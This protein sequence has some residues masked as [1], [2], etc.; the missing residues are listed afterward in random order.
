MDSE[1]D[2]LFSFPIKISLFE[3]RCSLSRA[4]ATVKMRI[5]M[6]GHDANIAKLCVPSCNGSM[7]IPLTVYARGGCTDT[8][9]CCLYTCCMVT[10]VSIRIES[11]F[12][13]Q[14]ILRRI[15]RQRCDLKPLISNTQVLLS[16]RSFNSPQILFHKLRRILQKP[17]G[18]DILQ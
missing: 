14:F 8:N 6:R 3:G 18:L 10:V 13:F 17:Q 4:E 11:W 2:V 1:L 5:Y 15:Q 16:I 9:N 7:N 12:R